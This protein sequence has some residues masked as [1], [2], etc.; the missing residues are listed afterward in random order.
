MKHDSLISH[1][2]AQTDSV[3]LALA[4]LLL[5]MSLASWYLILAKGWQWLQLRQRG[6]AFQQQFWQAASLDSVAQ[7]LSGQQLV[8]PFSRLAWQSLLARRQH[9]LIEPARLETAGSMTEV[10]TRQMQR[11][12]DD[13][14]TRLENGLTLLASVAAVAPFVGLFGTVWGVYHALTAIGSSGVAGLEQ[15]AG[16]VGEALIMTAFGLAV[17]IP[18]LLAYNACTRGNRVLLARLDRFAH[19]LFHFITTGQN[20]AAGREA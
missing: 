11:A 6:R 5:L 20:T 16:P 14:T 10:L 19:Q 18:A 2:L 9:A 17:A 1:F 7:Q 4:A 13:E 8:D 12:I 15:I 3:G